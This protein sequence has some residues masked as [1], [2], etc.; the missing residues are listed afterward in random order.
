MLA[1]TVD[2]AGTSK[3]ATA[4]AE[5]GTPLAA[6]GQG[7]EKKADCRKVID[8]I[9]KEAAKTKVENQAK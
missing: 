9:R 1:P 6:S 8:T 5:H 7:Y 4:V 2:Y 3:V